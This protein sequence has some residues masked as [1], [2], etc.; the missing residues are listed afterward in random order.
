MTD[1][2][3]EG[4]TVGVVGDDV[5]DVL[6]AAGARPV[7]GDPG[8]A[9]DTDPSVLVAVG[10]RA[11]AT[12]ARR[13]PAVPVVPVA[14]GR[15][16]RSVPRGELP[17]VARRLVE[18]DWTVDSHPLLAVVADGDRTLVAFDAM[19]VTEEPA[20]ISEYTVRTGGETVAQ[21]RADGVVVAT[22]AG[23]PGYSRAAGGPVVAT[24]L[25]VLVVV[26]VAPFATSLDHWVVPL[27]GVAVAVER[28]EA[29]VE[30][31]ADDRSVGT[32][33][34]GQPVRIRHAGQLDL[35]RVPESVSPFSRGTELEKL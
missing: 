30:V 29:P 28:D 31:L 25:D 32:A 14:A 2:P 10:E 7:H 21:F 16:T 17:R 24:G 1:Q 34:P 22:P 23:T 13:E 4:P 26:P 19:L 6:S 12:V 27:D 9:I 15:G 5:S 20:D 35:V 18:G 3:G 8:T 33:T 11:L